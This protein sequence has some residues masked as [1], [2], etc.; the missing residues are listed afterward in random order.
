MGELSLFAI[1]A[2]LIKHFIC[3]FPLQ[4]LCQIQKKGI[5]GNPYGLLHA[6]IHM[7]GT[8]FALFFF[9]P[10]QIVLLCS[11]IDGVLHY[12]IDWAKSNINRHFNL[13]MED[14]RSFWFWTLFGFDQLLHQAT[15]VLLLMLAIYIS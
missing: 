4:N 5:Y 3:D 11:A 15:Y 14:S 1:L 8:L 9:F 13:N 6:A 7:T 2:L 12:H 10:M